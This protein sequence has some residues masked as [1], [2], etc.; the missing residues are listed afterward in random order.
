MAKQDQKK[1]PRDPQQT[2]WKRIVRAVASTGGKIV[3]G[4]IVAVVVALI[5]SQILPSKS[6]T[7]PPP[8]EPPTLP[9][10]STALQA[11]DD[12]VPD[13]QGLVRERT[14]SVDANTYAEPFKQ[15][16]AG[17]DIPK[18]HLVLVSCKLYWPHPESVSE[19]GYW[20]RIVTE[21]WES[22][23]APANSFWNG[24]K[25]GQT[26]THSTNFR[27]KD[28]AEDELPDG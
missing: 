24:D 11:K 15:T 5:L 28:C 26:A 25:P 18:N 4:V 16:G 13:A 14:W 6:P 3:V 22:L 7:T 27:V 21:P 12:A 10:P 2:F 19:D 8:E 17:P 23:F 9:K 20:Y 1:P